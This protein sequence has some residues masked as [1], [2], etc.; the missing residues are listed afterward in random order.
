MIGS[1]SP[2]RLP[3]IRP[4]TVR[5]L[6]VFNED[7]EE[8]P[9]VR[10]RDSLIRAWIA[11]AA[12]RFILLT[13]SARGIPALPGDPYANDCRAGISGLGCTAA[14]VLVAGTLAP[15]VTGAGVASR[16]IERVA[17]LFDVAIL[18]KVR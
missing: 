17:R 2:G 7:V 16:L 10:W 9:L 3:V 11:W 5:L 14:L 18:S 13:F 6:S 4:V 8:F 15:V 1:S 12:G